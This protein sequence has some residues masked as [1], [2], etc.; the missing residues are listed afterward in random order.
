MEDD[1]AEEVRKLLTYPEDTAGGLMTT[2]FAVVRPNLTASQ[3]I[4]HLRMIGEE[5]ELLYYVYV[6][7]ESGHLIG[8]FSLPDLIMALPGTQ[9]SEFMNKRVVSVHLTDEQDEIAQVVAKYNLRAVPVVDD[10]ECLHGIVTADDALDKIIPTS[11]KKRL[12]RFFGGL[13]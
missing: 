13:K 1:E 4:K 6:T 5:I 7:D 12:P 11:W 3:T 9:V 10:N 2:E 8:D